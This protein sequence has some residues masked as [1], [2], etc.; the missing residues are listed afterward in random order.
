MSS[1][2]PSESAIS[3][4]MLV[5]VKAEKDHITE[6]SFP[7]ITGTV[8]NE[9]YKPIAN[10]NILIMFGTI[11]V[12]TTT[13]DQGNFQ[14]QSATPSTHGVYEVDA[15][16]TKD[17]YTKGLGTAIFTVS[18]RPVEQTPT[19]T[20]TGL[21]VEAGNYTV[22]LGRVAQW[23]LETTCFVDFSDR[24][25]RFLRSCDLYSMAPEDFQTDQQIIPMV[26]VI[27]YNGTYRLFPESI[28]LKAANMQNG[29]L[30]TFVAGTF[31]NYTAPQ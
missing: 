7:V 19:K 3:N 18:P 29:T 11:I 2:Q 28:Y 26:S 31:A 21:P 20:I 10:A 25:M 6:G 23:N 1:I 8:K 14:Y 4:K 17:G 13:D 12:S 22:F 30:E 9:A 24:H 16:A 5:S 27:H 15:T